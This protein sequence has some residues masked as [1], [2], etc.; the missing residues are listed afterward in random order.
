MPLSSVNNS[1]NS[2]SIAISTVLLQQ[3]QT[4]TIAGG[5]NR[6]V[7]SAI[8]AQGKEM[9]KANLDQGQQTEE[10]LNALMAI[11]QQPRWRAA[12][13]QVLNTS[14]VLPSPPANP[15]HFCTLGGTPSRWTSR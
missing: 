2:T 9:Q 5:A 8:A 14:P 7:Q 13:V 11:L 1:G 12:K 10:N 6:N 15:K 4:H 3:A